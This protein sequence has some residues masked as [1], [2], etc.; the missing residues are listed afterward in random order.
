[1]SLRSPLAYQIPEETA[2]VARA[3]FPKGNLVMHLQDHFGMLYSNP[4][5]TSLF[6]STGRPAEAPA[7]L[8]LVLVLQFIEGFPDRQAA[9]AVRS[10]IDW[11]YALALE[12][13]DSGFDAS[14]LS[15]FR[16]RLLSSQAEFLLL[17]TLLSLLQERGL[18]KPRARQRTDSTHVLAAIRT[19]NRLELVI[20]TLHLALE[21]LATVAPDWLHPRIRPGWLE[22]YG[23]R[24]ENAR[25][26]KAETQRQALASQVGADGFALLE[27]VYASDTPS[28]VRQAPAV[29]VLRQVWMQQYYGPGGPDE[30]VCWRKDTDAPPADRAIHS[31]HDLEARFSTKREQNW[32]GYK[33][34]LT[35]TCEEQQPRLITHVETTAA[36]RPDEHM[37]EPIHA[38]LEQK[39]LLPSEHVVDAG[40]TNAEVLVRSEREY[41]VQVIGPVTMDTSWQAREES[42]YASGAFVV[43]W[44]G[45]KAS[46]PEGQESVK[47]EERVEKSGQTVIKVHFG[48]RVC[49]ECA[50]RARCTKAARH[51]RV[52]TVRSKEQYEALQAARERQDTAAFQAAYAIRAGVEAS[53]SQGVRRSEMRRTRYIGMAKTHL[54]HILIA[55]GLNVVRAVSWLADPQVAPPRRGR[56]QALA[57]A[58]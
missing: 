45:R 43:D 15:E 26:P 5:F 7:R 47:W 27:E 39:G 1:M 30:R 33:V 20:E 48:H 53:I 13:T 35:E 32:V 14:L 4:Q 57:A 44:E 23:L 55:V 29:E 8:A 18:L 49:K 22:R 42:G 52:L 6:S 37:L 50:V 19:L 25:L 38:A 2:R 10:R 46:C 36:T 40:Y 16:S 17:D 11:K 12:L 58:A 24:A 21:Q 41:G 9:D 54:Q 3:A 34:H 51:P 28:V 56:F 31:P